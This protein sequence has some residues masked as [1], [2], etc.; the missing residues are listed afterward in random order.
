MSEITAV[1]LRPIRK[2]VLTTLWIGIAAALLL[3][4]GWAWT[5]TRAQVAA[6]QPA[7]D[8]L[9]ENA[10]R[11][12]VVTTA[13]GLQY[14][15]L[16]PGAGAKPGPGDVALIDYEGRLTNGEIFD[17][18]ASNGGPV[19]LPVSG[20]VPGFSEALQL[21]SRGAKYRVWLPP[22]LG[23]GDRAAGPIPPNSVIQFDIELHE[24]QAMPAGA[25]P[26]M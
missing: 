21:M 17:S 15:V 13:S 19:P 7:A 5:S 14:K 1:P 6:A 18:S 8:F 16:K 3:A 23:Y 26:Q 12:G 10:R 4:V 2:S 22:Q 25:A 20:V 11:S 9:A 24:F